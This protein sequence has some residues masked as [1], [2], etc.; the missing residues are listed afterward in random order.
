MTQQLPSLAAFER[1]VAARQNDAALN[2]AARILKTID[3]GMGAIGGIDVGVPFANVDVRDV[4][5]RFATRFVAAFGDLI[6]QPDVALSPNAVEMFFIYHRINDMMF[7]LSGFQTSAHLLARFAGG[8]N[9]QWQ[10]S[11][12]ALTQ[13]LLFYSPSSA[14]EINL[15]ECFAANPGLTVVAVLGYLS[16]RVCVTPR[17]CAFRERALEWLPGRL[18]NFT[19][20]RIRLGYM[21]EV[22]M[23]CSYASGPA[24]HRIKSDLIA[25]FRKVCEAEGGRDAVSPPPPREQPRIVV[26]CEHFREGHSVFRTHSRAVR[27]LRE[28][29]EVIG[30]GSEQLID[31]GA[32]ECFDE[33]LV[34]P[35]GDF[36]QSTCAVANQILERAPDIVFHLGVGMSN[37]SIAMAS[38]RLAPIQCVSYGHTATTMSSTIDYMVLPDDFVGSEDVFSEKVLRLPPEAIPYAPPCASEPPV[39]P[40]KPLALA[41]GVLRIAVPASVMKINAE[42]LAAL[43]Q[44]SARAKRPV[45]FHFF[46][47]AAVGVAHQYLSQEV[48]RLV[49]NSVVHAQSPRTEYLER[50]GAC[51]FFLCPFPYGNMNSIIDSMLMG[52]PG[53]CLD[54]PEAHSHAD[55]AIFHRLGLPDSLAAESLEDYV[56]A[57]VRLIDDPSWLEHCRV[58]AREIDLRERFYSG[59]ERQFCEAMYALLGRQDEPTAD[60]KPAPR[61]KATAKA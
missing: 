48:M 5:V 26:V 24:K 47:L 43:G 52:I 27:S 59:D 33:M 36:I 32:R 41:E 1:L 44:I 22:Y 45:E 7:S 4:H 53:V 30:V 39:P 42:F 34:Y 9:G 55:V 60:R 13:F 54:G 2:E 25:Q 50:L 20:G 57:A 31:A 29:F 6:T 49:P 37:F 11:G 51:A 14:L 17:G 46:P 40:R 56:T 35:P 58:F 3:D 10:L 28:R 16:A 21:A 12:P 38:L 18:E 61:R 15:D 8:P 19:L 23:H